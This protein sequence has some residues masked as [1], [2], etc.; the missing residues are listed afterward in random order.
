VKG[1]GVGVER[2][3]QRCHGRM[4]ALATY[5][6]IASRDRSDIRLEI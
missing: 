1:G 2:M 4:R 3:E 6:Y 5:K